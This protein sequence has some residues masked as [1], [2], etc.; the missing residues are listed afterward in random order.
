MDIPIELYRCACHTASDMDRR[1]RA[2]EYDSL[3]FD[4]HMALERAVGVLNC[5]SMLMYGFEDDRDSVIERIA[6]LNALVPKR[7]NSWP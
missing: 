6:V 1:F 3:G 4:A 7:M 2:G 5:L